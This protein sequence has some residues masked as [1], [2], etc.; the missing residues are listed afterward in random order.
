[1]TVKVKA[2]TVVFFMIDID[3]KLN[4][5]ELLRVYGALLTPHQAEI[6]RQ[7]YD[8]DISLFEIASDLD[9]SRQ[10][11]RDVLVRSVKTLKDVDKKLRLI[12]R[13]S[14]ILDAINAA[15]EDAKKGNVDAAIERLDDAVALLE[16]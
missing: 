14:C 2:F 11:V 7:Y 1:M 10:A 4:V 12:E 6:M 3:E 5:S 8:C 15:K 9:V 16:E 13:S